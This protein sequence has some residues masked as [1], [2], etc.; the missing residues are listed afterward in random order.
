MAAAPT[1]ESTGWTEQLKSIGGLRFARRSAHFEATVGFYR[2]LIGLTLL[3]TFEENYG[4]TGAIFGLP[5]AAVTFEIVRAEEPIA[6][7]SHEQLCLYLPDSSA[8]RHAIAR[9]VAAGVKPV[10]P[11]PYWAATGA[12]TYRDPDG[13][14]VVFAPFIFAVAPADKPA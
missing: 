11:H 13:R 2:D 5:G 8:Q 1:P 6:V 12:T 3:E 7:D 10:D 14:K 9:L 4:S